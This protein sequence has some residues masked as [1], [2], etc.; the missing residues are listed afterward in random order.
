ME[1]SASNSDPFSNSSSPT[2][3]RSSSRFGLS[4]P[5]MNFFRSPLSVILD[6]SGILPTRA[7]RHESEPV[8]VNGA[9]TPDLRVFSQNH[10]HLITPSS[11]SSSSSTATTSSGNSSPSGEVSIRIIG[12]G[13]Q[14]PSSSGLLPSQALV[15]QAGYEQNSGR[16]VS[17]DQPESPDEERVPL[18]PT[19]SS[20]IQSGS[21]RVDGESGNGVEESVNRDSS[22]QRY[23]IQQVARWIEQILP[24]SLLL[25]IVFIRQHLEGAFFRLFLVR[26]IIVSNFT[27]FNTCHCF[28]RF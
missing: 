24:F 27:T 2:T 7:V 16:S 17:G 13:E 9:A 6:Y 28:D 1:T 21:S 18:V 25:L 5:S 8:P 23:D 10:N 3:A 20:S 15:G 26:P 4:L 12:S 11:S 14:D 22:Y 19:A